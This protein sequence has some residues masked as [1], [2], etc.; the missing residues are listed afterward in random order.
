MIPWIAY[1]IEFYYSEK[2]ESYIKVSHF[3][4][5]KLSNNSY[6][7]NDSHGKA[8][9]NGAGQ[10]KGSFENLW[11]LREDDLYMDRMALVAVLGKVQE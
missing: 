1:L 9:E 7:G 3:A 4:P 2:F 6:Q 11:H 5:Y 10:T 8:E